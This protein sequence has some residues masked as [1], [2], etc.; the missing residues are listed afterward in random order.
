MT[1]FALL[2]PVTVVD[3]VPPDER[4]RNPALAW[5]LAWGFAVWLLDACLLHF[6]VSNAEGKPAS[7]RIDPVSPSSLWFGLCGLLGARPDGKYTSLF[8]LAIV[9]R[10]SC[11]CHVVAQPRPRV[12][13]RRADLR[14]R[15]E[16]HAVIAA[17]AGFIG[18]RHPASVCALKSSPPV[19]AKA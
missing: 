10:A 14:E 13:A 4:K 18:G 15:A 8:L 3:A 2:W 5:P 6:G 12:V 7:L 11:C 1:V 17:V 9:G 19:A 16:G